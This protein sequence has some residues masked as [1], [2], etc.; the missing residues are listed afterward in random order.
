MATASYDDGDRDGRRARES[1]ARSGSA[2]A[3][4]RRTDRT[5][6]AARRATEGGGDG[7]RV[8]VFETYVVRCHAGLVRMKAISHIILL[9]ELSAVM[10]Y[11]VRRVS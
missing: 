8:M 2:R 6:A 1:S 4:T 7:G 10:M 3:W 5:T 9:N 11:L